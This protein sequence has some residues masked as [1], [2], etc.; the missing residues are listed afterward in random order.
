MD[1]DARVLIPVQP[2]PRRAQ[3]R[4]EFAERPKTEP[5]FYD[6]AAVERDGRAVGLLRCGYQRDRAAHAEPDD[7]GRRRRKSLCGKVFACRRE[8]DP[9]AVGRQRRHVGERHIEL[10]GER[11]HTFAVV[12]VWGDRVVAQC[13]EPATH[14]DDVVV[15]AE[16]FLDDDE[17]AAHHGVRY[18]FI[19]RDGPI[20]A[21]ELQAAVIHGRTLAARIAWLP[22]PERLT[23]RRRCKGPRSSPDFARPAA[24]SPTTKRGSSWL[25]R[26]TRPTSTRWSSAASPVSHSSTCSGLLS[27]AVFASRSSRVYSC[28]VVEASFWSPRPLKPLRVSSRVRSSLTCAAVR[29]P[30]ALRWPRD[31]SWPSCMLSTSTRWRCGVRGATSPPQAGTCMKVI[32][33]SRCRSRCAGASTSS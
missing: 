5:S 10:V 3:H 6:A 13:C 33:T 19:S 17:R 7:A 14:V 22:P 24:C 32:C 31:S 8:M 23:C 28:R 20:G 15:H 25:R 21:G 27:S 16:C 4:G 1:G 11:A 29:V 12:Q 30:S 2:Q 26:R 18:H 9:S